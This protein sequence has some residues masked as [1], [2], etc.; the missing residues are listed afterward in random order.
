MHIP[1][2]GN[3]FNIENLRTVPLL[4]AQG[5]AGIDSS[6]ENS[7]FDYG[8]IWREIPLELRDHPEEDYMFVFNVGRINNP[9]YDQF[10]RVGMSSC[11]FSS[12]TSWMTEKDWN[13]FLSFQ[14]QTRDEWM[15]HS[16]PVRIFDLFR[17]WGFMCVFGST[18]YGGA[19]DIRDP[20]REYGSKPMPGESPDDYFSRLISDEEWGGEAWIPQDFIRTETGAYFACPD[21]GS[22]MCNWHIDMDPVYA[23]GSSVIADKEVPLDVL[24]SAIGIME[25]RAV[26]KTLRGEHYAAAEAQVLIGVLKAALN[27]S[28]SEHAQQAD[29]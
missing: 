29:Q 23:V 1:H 27:A 6:L 11:D 28:P 8:C 4:W 17:Y 24:E 2:P 7:L 21:F 9:E 12:D 14:G 3:P 10:A 25:K 5:F 15:Q 19:F 26:D 22:W 13:S 20:N 18:I 16:Y